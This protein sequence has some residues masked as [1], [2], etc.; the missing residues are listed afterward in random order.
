MNKMIKLLLSSVAVFFLASCYEDKGNYDYRELDDVDVSFESPSCLL[1]PKGK[2]ETLTITPS[3]KRLLSKNNESDL[4]FLWEKGAPDLYHTNDYKEFSRERNGKL[5]VSRDDLNGTKIRLTVTDKNEGIKWY[6][7]G[8]L[9]IKLPYSSAWFL[10]QDKGGK[11]IL[12]AIDNPGDTKNATVL[13]DVHKRENEGAELSVK[14]TPKAL[15]ALNI[16]GMTE[17]FYGIYSRSPVK[18]HPVVTVVTDKDLGTYNA[19][20]FQ[21]EYEANDMFLYPVMVNNQLDRNISYYDMTRAGEIAID[22]DTLYW[23]VPDGHAVMFKVNPRPK[24]ESN[25]PMKITHVTECNRGVRYL[26]Y[27]E[28]NDRLCYIHQGLDFYDMG[29]YNYVSFTYRARSFKPD[30][31]KLLMPSKYKTVLTYSTEE[32]MAIDP[33]QVKKNNPSLN[34]VTLLRD[35]RSAIVVLSEGGGKTLKLFRIFE[36]SGS[37][38]TLADNLLEL[39]FPAEVD[40]VEDVKFIGSYG[41]GDI[42]FASY[43][44]TVY[45]IRLNSSGKCDVNEI[46]KHSDA[47]VNIKAMKF[48]DNKRSMNWDIHDNCTVLGL[49]VEYSEQESGVIELDLS[50]PGD[51]KR[52]ENS[53]REYK[54]LGK[55]VDFAYSY[56]DPSI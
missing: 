26:L 51:V 30:H 53:V 46:Y 21:K 35:L 2:T 7:E 20:T 31:L 17:G 36:D 11:P 50:I 5:V 27:D 41:Y 48:R 14:G 42:I 18:R 25:N 32:K 39:E 22:N 1:P 47:N 24:T 12:S 33:N 23:A 10:L 19:V 3:I 13:E 37:E 52:A 40:K 56:L 16:Y 45:K 28:A 15:T 6:A 43:K 38:G 34:V 8:K 55:V 9:T 44:N 29:L 54:G 4:E 49:L